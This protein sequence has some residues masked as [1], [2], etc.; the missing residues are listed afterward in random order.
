MLLSLLVQRSGWEGG[1]FCGARQDVLKIVSHLH[2]GVW[3]LNTLR[4]MVSKQCI[5]QALDGRLDE[6][7]TCLD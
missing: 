4:V 3:P 5:R 7:L 2:A 1:I 6:V